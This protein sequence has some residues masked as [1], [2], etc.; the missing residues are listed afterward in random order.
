MIVRQRTAM[1]TAARSLGVMFLGMP[2]VTSL[3]S[4]A[5]Q[6]WSLRRAARVYL[7]DNGEK[8]SEGRG[9]NQHPQTDHDRH[10]GCR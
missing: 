9:R 7:A 3:R 8:A 2:I 10:G 1:Q 5:G 6:S 4:F